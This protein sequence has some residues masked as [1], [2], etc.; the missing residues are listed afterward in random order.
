[1]K[2]LTLVS[3]SIALCLFGVFRATAL[4]LRRYEKLVV[5]GDSLSD[6][7]N[8]FALSALAS[9]RQPAPPSGRTKMRLGPRL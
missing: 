4:D 6:D 2:T 8:L 5:F 3:L 1:M 7:G 9:P